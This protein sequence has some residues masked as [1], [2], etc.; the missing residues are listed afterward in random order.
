MRSDDFTHAPLL[1]QANAMVVIETS[2]GG[3]GSWLRGLLRHR[4]LVRAIRRADGYCGHRTYWRPRWTVGAMGWFSAVDDVR[5]F[6]G[7]SGHPPLALWVQDPA[8]V[9]ETDVKV[10][11]AAPQ[12]Y[13]NG[14]WRAEGDVFGLIERFTPV[15]DEVEGPLVKPPRGPVSKD[16]TQ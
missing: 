12:G 1:A 3:L 14:V 9:A 13:T 10:Y 8:R 7:H 6:A 11:Q 16:A 15:R 2:H 5:R 4:R